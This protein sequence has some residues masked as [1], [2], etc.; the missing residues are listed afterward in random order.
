MVVSREIFDYI[1]HKCGA[2][3]MDENDVNKFM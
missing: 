2:I 3:K 1:K